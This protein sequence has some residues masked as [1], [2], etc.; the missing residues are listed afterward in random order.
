MSSLHETKK[1][2]SRTGALPLRSEANDDNVPIPPTSNAPKGVTMAVRLRGHM[3]ETLIEM[4]RVADAHALSVTCEAWNVVV[5]KTFSHWTQGSR[6]VLAVLARRR[7]FMQ[8][9]Y[10]RHRPRMAAERLCHTQRMGRACHDTG[11]NC[12]AAPGPGAIA[13]S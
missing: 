5:S 2:Q 13:R 8:Q 12:P 1:R 4:L 3:S 10:I 6:T 9:V 7:Q 11:L